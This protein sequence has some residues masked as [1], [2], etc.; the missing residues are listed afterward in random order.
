MPRADEAQL[1]AL[2]VALQQERQLRA[3]IEEELLRRHCNEQQ[4][5]Q[6]VRAQQRSRASS[7]FSLQAA[8]QQQQQ[9]L[10][11]Q[12]QQH[13]HLLAPMYG[14]CLPAVSQ[15][16]NTLTTTNGNKSLEVIVEAIRHLEGDQLFVDT[17]TQQVCVSVQR[18]KSITTLSL[19]VAF[20]QAGLLGSSIP[21]ESL[22]AGAVSRAL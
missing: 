17:N 20:R 12:L 7:T 6:Q 13:E 10:A 14:K 19:Q 8:L 4:A 21:T 15:A 18:Q 11:A 16:G 9:L 22:F 1:T 2:Q 5:A 3:I